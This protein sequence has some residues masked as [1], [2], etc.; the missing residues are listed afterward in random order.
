[1]KYY[2]I[3]YMHYGVPT[4]HSVSEMSTVSM[5]HPFQWIK[6][7]NSSNKINYSGSTDWGSPSVRLLD[8][9]E[10]SDEE[11]NMWGTV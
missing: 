4:T 2:F 1:M 11:F 10:I 9:K 3:R 6:E 5:A 8:Y 7:W